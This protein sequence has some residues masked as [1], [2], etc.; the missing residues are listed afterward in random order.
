MKEFDVSIVGAG[1]VGCYIACD[2]AKKG[3][4]SVCVFEEHN[5][6]G[7]PTN[8]AGLITKK[9][10][11]M[12]NIKN[13][14]I[15]QNH[16]YGAKI[17]SPNGTKLEIGGEKPRAIVIDRY[18]FDKILAKKA[19]DSGAKIFLDTRINKITRLE[20]KIKIKN[21]SGKTETF[22]KLLLGTDGPNSIVRKSFSF[23][24]PKE[25]LKC[26]GAEITGVEMDPKFVEIILNS[27]IAPGFFAWAIPTNNKGTS[28]RIGLGT[29]EFKANL[30]DCFNNLLKLKKYKKSEIQNYI[31][32]TVPLGC[33]D[34]IVDSNILLAGDSAA[35]VKPTS[36]GGIFPGLLCA[37]HC[38]KTILESFGKGSFNKKN[39]KKY[40][41]SCKLEIGRELAI[42]MRVRNVFKK[43]NDQ[44]LEKYINKLNTRQTIEIIN[45]FG[46]IDFPSKLVLPLL[47]KNPSFLKLLPAI[48]RSK[49]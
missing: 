7:K 17:Y 31:G 47:K 3:E 1:P 15:I 39:L 23:P 40:Q 42:G 9:S 22:S 48:V 41:S 32:G 18:L 34:K 13:K 26:V 19:I 44:Q 25:Y 35:Q 20:N 49:D 4:M 30:K 27:K 11:D 46:D 24:E 12:A 2:I 28:V 38:S 36:G 16:I 37:K 29:S 6:I 33:L 8:C 21:E 43:L 45:E 10:L 14:S 5:E